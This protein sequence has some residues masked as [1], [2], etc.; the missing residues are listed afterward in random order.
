MLLEVDARGLPGCRIESVRTQRSEEGHP[1]DDIVIRGVDQNGNAAT[2]EM[3]VKRS[4]TFTA[5]DEEFR[6]VVAQMG[7]AASLEGFWTNHHQLGIAVARPTQST[8]PS[9][10]DVL[11]WARNPENAKTF[12]ERLNR[13]GTSNQTMR[14]FVSVFRNN[15]EAAGYDHGDEFVW[16]LLRRVQILIFDFDSP[17]APTTELMCERSLRA[18]ENG[19]SAEA[20]KLWS[21]LITLAEDMAE[22]GGSKNR[23][24][25]ITALHAFRFVERD[26]I[27]RRSQRSSKKQNWR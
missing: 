21:Q 10:Q 5:S 19:S 3:Q 20:S 8:E 14:N 4:M 6:D 13:T 12:H 26:A 2:L 17:A 1:L 9:Y 27:S 16:K 7:K 23:A 15:L 24:E 22:V 11:S 18:L 25:L